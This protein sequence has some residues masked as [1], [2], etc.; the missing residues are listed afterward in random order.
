MTQTQMT[1]NGT[2]LLRITLGVAALAHGLLK[3]FVFT[4][5]G[6]AGYF[7]SLGLPGFLAYLTVLAEIGGGLALIAG[8]QTRLVALALIPVLLGAAWAHAGNGW[9]FSN[10]GG[11]WEYPLFWAFALAAQSLLGSGAHAVDDLMMRKTQAA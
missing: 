3:I 8:F 10:Q 7:E 5:P 1:A 11:G 4:L 6:T 9:L 2:A